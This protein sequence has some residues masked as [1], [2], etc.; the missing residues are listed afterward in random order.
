MIHYN[1][2]GL[3]GK[4]QPLFLRRLEANLLRATAGAGVRR[5]EERSGRMVLILTRE[6]DWAVIRERLRSVFGIANFALA[7]RVEPDMAVLKAALGK[8]LEGRSFRSFKVATRRA[9]KQFPLNSEEVNRELGAFVQGQT[10]AA[11]DLER[12]DLTIHVEVLPRDIYFSCGREA[13]PGGLPLGVSGRVVCL[14]SGGIDSPVAA[15]RLMKRGCQVVFVHFHG[16]PYLD[17]TSRSKAMELARV[18]TRFQ[19]QSRLYVVP[20]GEIQREVV[21]GAPAPLRIVLYR[22]LMGRIAE[23]IAHR[24]YAKALVTGESLGQVA[25]QTL[26]NLAVIEEA[27][28]MPLLRPLI[29]SDKEEIVQQARALGTYEIS[30]IPDQDCCRLFVPQHPATI[31]SLE[32]VR[33]AE[34]NL[35]VEKLIQLGLDQVEI[36]GFEFPDGAH[37]DHTGGRQDTVTP[38]EA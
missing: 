2:I 19:Y 26:D 4:N 23:Q 9:Y 27:V 17:G 14:L 28:G 16:G 36:Q 3:K 32:E 18:L 34:A 11:V 25:S 29:G 37:P 33:A 8:T 10:R 12:P 13:G 24:E 35:S 15:H 31:S 20:F 30:I 21:V 6:V 22:R 1:E 7:E 38:R 5:V